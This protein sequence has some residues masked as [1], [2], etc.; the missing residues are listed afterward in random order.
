MTNN[1]FEIFHA[2]ADMQLFFDFEF[3]EFEVVYGDRGLQRLLKDIC[4]NKP[5]SVAGAGI[6][7]KPLPLMTFSV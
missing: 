6:R 2:D 4:N 3:L 1:G 5:S 7:R